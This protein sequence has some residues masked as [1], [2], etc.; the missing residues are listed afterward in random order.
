MAS[1]TFV[2]TSGFHSLLVHRDRMHAAAADYMA[3]AARD[4]GRFVTTGYVLDIAPRRFIPGSPT[5]AGPA[6]PMTGSQSH[7][8]VAQAHRRRT[9]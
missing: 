9:G 7:G 5:L 6:A 3:R 8:L 1:E 2:D 4:Q